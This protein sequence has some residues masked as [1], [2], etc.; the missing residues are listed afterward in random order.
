MLLMFELWWKWKYDANL[1]GPAFLCLL[2]VI[3]IYRYFLQTLFHS[4]RMKTKDKDTVSGDKLPKLEPQDP[5]GPQVQIYKNID[6]GQL[7]AIK[8]DGEGNIIEACPIKQ[9]VD[10]ANLELTAHYNEQLRNESD[11]LTLL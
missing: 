7:W 5:N 8:T 11:R 4:T 2:V 10:P 6:T 3:L 9:Y 1:M